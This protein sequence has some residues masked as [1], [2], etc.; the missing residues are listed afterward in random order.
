M[1]GRVSGCFIL[2]PLKF[3]VPIVTI[4]VIKAIR[5]TSISIEFTLDQKYLENSAT[6]ILQDT[7]K[8]WHRGE[9]AS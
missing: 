5:V 1:L 8:V 7:T 6:M 2:V 3:H 9:L 4:I